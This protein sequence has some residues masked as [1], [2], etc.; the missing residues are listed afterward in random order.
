MMSEASE[1][2]CRAQDRSEGNREQSRSNTYN[3]GRPALMEVMSHAVF[4]TLCIR[5]AT[6]CAIALACAMAHSAAKRMKRVKIITIT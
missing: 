3:I 6:L 1:I 2:E 4:L 5:V